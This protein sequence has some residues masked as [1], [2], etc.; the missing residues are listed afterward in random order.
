MF[1]EMLHV[2][3]ISLEYGLPVFSRQPWMVFM[4]TVNS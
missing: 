1:S 2:L 4:D 3:K